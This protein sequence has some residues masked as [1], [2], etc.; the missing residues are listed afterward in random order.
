MKLKMRSFRGSEQ[1]LRS[2]Q[3][4]QIPRYLPRSRQRRILGG[5]ISDHFRSFN[6]LEKSKKLNF[7]LE[8]LSL[9]M[10]VQE[11]Y[12]LNRLMGYFFQIDTVSTAHEQFHWIL[13]LKTKKNIISL[14]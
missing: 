12:K 2:S 4:R 14:L 10:K 11:K 13:A 3:S 8:M 9:F 1:I 7:S 6:G 5:L